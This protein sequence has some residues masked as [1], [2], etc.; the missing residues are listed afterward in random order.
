[1]ISR[2]SCVSEQ[3]PFHEVIA[4]AVDGTDSLREYFPACRATGIEAKRR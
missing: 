1:L 2:K 3:F 4:R